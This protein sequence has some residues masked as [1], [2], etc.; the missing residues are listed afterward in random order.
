M[1]R[2]GQAVLQRPPVSSNDDV[3][4]KGGKQFDGKTDCVPSRPFVF[5]FYIKG[6]RASPL[7]IGSPFYP[8]RTPP[9]NEASDALPTS[10][11]DDT[12]FRVVLLSS[13]KWSNN[14]FFFSFRGCW[15]FYKKKSAR[16]HIK[17]L[18]LPDHFFLN[19]EESD[20]YIPC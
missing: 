1:A 13:L 5:R 16:V 19:C 8:Y 11:A 14:F 10:P 9:R 15:L 18:F 7:G 4:C 20:K 6:R 17:R 3:I 2:G 12:I